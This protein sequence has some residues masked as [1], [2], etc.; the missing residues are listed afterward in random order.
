MDFLYLF[1]GL[2]KARR[3]RPASSDDGGQC[4][5]NTF[6]LTRLDQ[7]G[8][9]LSSH[10]AA[11]TLHERSL[12]LVILR[13][14][15]RVRQ[16]RCLGTTQANQPMPNTRQMSATG[17]PLLRHT[18]RILALAVSQIGSIT[19]VC[20]VI[21][22]VTRVKSWS[23]PKHF[24]ICTAHRY[25]SSSLPRYF[26]VNDFIDATILLFNLSIR[27]SLNPRPQSTPR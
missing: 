25:M 24:R 2:Q 11:D 27:R 23:I 12:P 13:P 20:T 3:P 6:C 14:C 5:K 9:F 22:I 4:L 17:I 26:S 21:I 19:S 1:V 10:V 18:S 8:P 7:P 16:A 15:V